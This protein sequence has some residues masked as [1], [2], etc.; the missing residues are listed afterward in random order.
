MNDSNI[1]LKKFHYCRLRKP[2]TR[3]LF[4][5]YYPISFFYFF[6]I[7]GNGTKSFTYVSYCLYSAIEFRCRIITILT[8]QRFMPSRVGRRAPANVVRTMI[9]MNTFI[10][11][12]YEFKSKR[13]SFIKYCTVTDIMKTHYWMVL[14]FL[15]QMDKTTIKS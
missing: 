13:L 14:L 5:Q 11:K 12:N 7:R 2:K 15:F 3:I 9:G 8:V 4:S 1:R 6:S 10:F